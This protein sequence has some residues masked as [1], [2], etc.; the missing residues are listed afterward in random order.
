MNGMTCMIS[1]EWHAIHN[2]HVMTLFTRHAACNV[3][4]A[5]SCTPRHKYLDTY[6]IKET[7]MTP[8]SHVIYV[9]HDMYVIHV[10]DIQI[11]N[12]L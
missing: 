7:T 6:P 8:S 5:M 12:L 11:H 4:F 10:M 2:I 1:H 9:T 3:I